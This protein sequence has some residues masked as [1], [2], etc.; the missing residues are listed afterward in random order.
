MAIMPRPSLTDILERLRD[1]EIDYLYFFEAL[2]RDAD[3]PVARD[4]CLKLV[5]IFGLTP[6]LHAEVEQKFGP[7]RAKP[8][9]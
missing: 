6:A 5:H 1:L 4:L 7:S 3:D 2:M 9:A 8:S